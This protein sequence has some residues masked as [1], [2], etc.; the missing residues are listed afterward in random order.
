[1]YMYMYMYTL[2]NTSTG[3]SIGVNIHIHDAELVCLHVIE[4]SYYIAHY[5]KRKE[6]GKEGRKK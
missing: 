4:Q 3:D 2:I 6:E 1:M 5:I